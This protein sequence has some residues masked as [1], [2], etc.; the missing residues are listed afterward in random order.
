MSI[1][2]FRSRIAGRYVDEYLGKWFETHDK[3]RFQFTG[4]EVQDGQDFV[5]LRASGST[6]SQ[7]IPRYLF[8]QCL[9][10]P[11]IREVL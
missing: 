10:R 6:K 3:T 9:L 1:L 4:Y 2:S 8:E 11:T 5:R 7:R